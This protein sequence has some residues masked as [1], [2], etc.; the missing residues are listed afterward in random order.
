MFST[1]ITQSCSIVFYSLLGRWFYPKQPPVERLDFK[2]LMVGGFLGQRTCW[3][4]G[5]PD[6]HQKSKSVLSTSNNSLWW[7][8]WGAFLIIELH[9]KQISCLFINL[10]CSI[11]DS[12]FSLYHS[13]FSVFKGVFLGLGSAFNMEKKCLCVKE[14]WRGFDG[15]RGRERELMMNPHKQHNGVR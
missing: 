14:Q 7:R 2:H 1:T 5:S 8:T 6:F 4:I 12:S 3:T 9:E 15:R 11:L 13:A 10:L